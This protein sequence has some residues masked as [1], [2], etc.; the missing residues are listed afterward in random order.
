MWPAARLDRL[1]RAE[2][3]SA[4]ETTTDVGVPA[5]Q[6][7]VMDRTG[8]ISHVGHGAGCHPTRGIAPLRAL[9][10]AVGA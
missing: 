7:L 8:E 6:C 1:A 9:T 10:E 2:L 4:W 3:M 5:F